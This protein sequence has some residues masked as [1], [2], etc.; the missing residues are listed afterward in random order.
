MTVME[1]FTP[2][3]SIKAQDFDP[4]GVLPF[5]ISSSVPAASDMLLMNYATS[6]HFLLF[7]TF[8]MS[9]LTITLFIQSVNLFPLFSV[10][11][12]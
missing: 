3:P 10:W 11:I 1:L 4:F 5:H 7:F 9:S 2:C 8:A 12:S 6:I